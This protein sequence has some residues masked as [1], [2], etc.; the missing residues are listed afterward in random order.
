MKKGHHLLFETVVLTF[1]S[2]MIGMIIC[3]FIE[4]DVYGKIDAIYLVVVISSSFIAGMAFEL[5]TIAIK[6]GH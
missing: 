4:E 1:M 3:Y 5:V 2:I 6:R